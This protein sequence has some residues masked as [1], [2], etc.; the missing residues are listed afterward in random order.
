MPT[1]AGLLTQARLPTDSGALEAELLLAFCLEKDRSYL[2]TWPEQ[3]VE[4]P[5]EQRYQQLLEAR[6]AGKP[7]AYL[8]GSRDFWTLSL[9]VDERCLIP[10]PE[11]ETLVEWA[12][13]LDLPTTA[14]VSD[15]GTGSG[16]IALALA[17]ER[18]EWRLTALDADPAVIELALENARRLRIDNV[19]FLH[20]NWGEALTGECFDLLV[21]N[22]PYVVSDDE[23]LAQ[24]D[25]RFEPR[26]ALAAGVDGLDDLRTITATAPAFLNHHG[27]LLVEH[28]YDQGP[29]V[30]QLLEAAGF[31]EIESRRD[32]AGHERISGGRWHDQ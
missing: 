18:P 15:W 23:H 20:S 19:E 1:I 8:V 17:G 13:E 9:S 3:E 28:G 6:R 10:R 5:V 12:L 24:G 21:S 7:I 4:L 22:P 31:K 29:A 26:A 14:R 25:V 2:Y 32:L 11:T 16:A 27:W 30:R